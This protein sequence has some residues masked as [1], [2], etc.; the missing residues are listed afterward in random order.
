MPE[1]EV[2][3]KEVKK[4][5]IKEE[6]IKV[7]AEPKNLNEAIINIRVELQATDVKKSGKNPHA[8]F[9]YYELKDFLPTLNTLMLKYGVNDLITFET[10]EA[11]LTL[12]KGDEKQKYAMPFKQYET[13]LTNAGKQSMQD[14]QYLGALTT[15]YKRY[16][17]LNAFGI[18]DGEVIDSM[19]NDDT[20]AADPEPKPK[21]SRQ[22]QQ[23][24]D[25]E[26]KGHSSL[27]DMTEEEATEAARIKGLSGVMASLTK[28]ENEEFKAEIVK[29]V[30]AIVET[31]DW[32][33]I[34]FTDRLTYAK[35]VDIVKGQLEQEKALKE[36]GI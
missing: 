22:A 27:G 7:I 3:E 35:F 32:W 28:P 19:N 21:P 12:I 6:S 17:Y 34:Q 9:G 2:K 11:S 4:A 13:P 29:N 25:V 1:K 23:A 20:P 31:D 24:H 5:A 33:K 30:L 14:I 15:Y 8:R 10:D 36:I 16:L 26:Y 18:T